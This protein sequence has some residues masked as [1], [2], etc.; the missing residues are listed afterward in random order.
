MY[1]SSDRYGLCVMHIY[2][3][4]LVSS[5]SNECVG[6]YKRKYERGV[7]VCVCGWMDRCRCASPS[8][9]PSKEPVRLA[10]PTP[11]LIPPPGLLPGTPLIVHI[12]PEGYLL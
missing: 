10:P 9:A 4:A 11:N 8:H 7:C 3:G 6:T 12:Y 5:S 1:V 2:A